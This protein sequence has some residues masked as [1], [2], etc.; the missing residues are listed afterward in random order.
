MES[1]LRI[2]EKHHEQNLAKKEAKATNKQRGSSGVCGTFG[3]QPRVLGRDTRSS[4]Y[5][6][7][8]F[9]QFLSLSEPEKK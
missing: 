1:L 9:G 2:Q 7:R 6:L 8:G 3:K 4:F 5:L